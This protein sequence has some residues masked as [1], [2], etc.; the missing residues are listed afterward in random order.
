M[1]AAG[2]VAGRAAPLL[3]TARAQP[4]PPQHSSQEGG[5]HALNLGHTPRSLHHGDP[6]GQHGQ[7]SQ[8]ETTGTQ[9]A[10][11]QRPWPLCVILGASSE[12]RKQRKSEPDGCS[13]EGICSPALLGEG[14]LLPTTTSGTLQVRAVEA[15]R[16][17]LLP[18][19]F[20]PCSRAPRRPQWRAVGIV[21]RPP[22]A[23]REAGVQCPHSRAPTTWKCTKQ[24]WRNYPAPFKC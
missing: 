24:G 14:A 17:E 6:A 15:L 9:Q 19:P 4:V 22:R 5:T 18:R 7:N 10:V 3:P 11:G 13:G 2:L 23:R 8:K 12:T 21:S 16:L 20:L 1:E